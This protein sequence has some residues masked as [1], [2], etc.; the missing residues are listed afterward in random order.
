MM[1]T[2]K[3]KPQQ[4]AD[5]LNKKTVDLLKNQII[6]DTSPGTIVKDFN[7]LLDFI[8][9]QKVQVTPEINLLGMKYLFTLNEKLSKP[10]K[11]SLKRPQ[12]HAFPNINGLYLLLRASGFGKIIKE[13]SKNYLILDN[14][15]IN[16]WKHLNHTEQYFSL[17]KIWLFYC[18]P[19][20]IRERCFGTFNMGRCITFILEHLKRKL[21]VNKENEDD[22]RILL[23]ILE[24]SIGL[25]NVVLAELFGLIKVEKKEPSQDKGIKISRVERTPFGLAA[26]KLMQKIWKNE[27]Y[28]FFIYAINDCEIE[29]KQWQAYFR[30]FFP[31]LKK[32][33]SLPEIEY[34]EGLYVFKISL[35]NVWREISITSQY[36][37]DSLCTFILDIFDFDYDHLYSVKVKNTFGGFTEYCHP[38]M[39]AVCYTNEIAIGELGL[40][41]GGSMKFI[42]DFRDW[43]EFEILLKEIREIKN[44]D[45]EPELLKK[46]GTPP[47]QYPSEDDW[48]D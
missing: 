22:A 25:Y 47:E 7:I 19:E 1:K 18:D 8:A 40:Q 5:E 6:T 30:L 9:S 2:K 12:Q 37:L 46:H 21:V 17:M 13:G 28:D 42:Y 11:V 33:L 34:I 39:D 3:L 14:K 41:E 36:D 48:D 10:V 44:K 16:N 15:M 43:W 27:V 29:F 4:I 31:E 32:D 38:A 23:E 45:A 20:I 24:S 26:A 35:G